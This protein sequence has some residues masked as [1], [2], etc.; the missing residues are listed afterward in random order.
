MEKYTLEY[1]EKQRH[2]HFNNGTHPLNT[3]GWQTIVENGDDVEL[4][5]FVKLVE[6]LPYPVIKAKQIIGLWKLFTYQKGRKLDINMLNE[7][8]P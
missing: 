1:N 3:H 5:L 2:Y 4:T 8:Q 6:E 7:F